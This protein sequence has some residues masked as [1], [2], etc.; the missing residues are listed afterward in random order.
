[1]GQDIVWGQRTYLRCTH[2][3]LRRLGNSKKRK[4]RLGRRAGTVISFSLHRKENH[5]PQELYKTESTNH[6]GNLSMYKIT[7]AEKSELKVRI[8]NWR[9]QAQGRTM[10][11]HTKIHG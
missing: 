5:L 2:R 1:M 4:T 3:P 8:S 10:T 11:N 6:L 9:I 7:V